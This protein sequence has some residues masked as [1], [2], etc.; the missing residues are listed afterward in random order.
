MYNILSSHDVVS[1]QR[2]DEEEKLGTP[3]RVLEWIA[4]TLQQQVPQ[5]V[6]DVT[7]LHARYSS[8]C[9]NR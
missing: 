7:V 1:F 4:R 3:V 8:R 2:Y 5:P 6:S 9:P